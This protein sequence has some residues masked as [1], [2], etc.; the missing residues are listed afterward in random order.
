VSCR[1]PF[2]LDNEVLLYDVTSRY[3]EG[4]AEANPLAQ[5]GYSGAVSLTSPHVEDEITL[6][7]LVSPQT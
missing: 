1:T 4:E 5:R 2:A 6:L 7:I 3:F